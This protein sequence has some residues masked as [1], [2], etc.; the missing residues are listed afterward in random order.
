[1]KQTNSFLVT[2]PKPIVRISYPPSPRTFFRSGGYL[3]FPTLLQ[4]CTIVHKIPCLRHVIQTD[5]S[6]R[7]HIVTDSGYSSFSLYGCIFKI[8]LL[9]FSVSKHERVRLFTKSI[10]KIPIIIWTTNFYLLKE[11]IIKWVFRLCNKIYLAVAIKN[12]FTLL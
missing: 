11:F 6:E 7:E 10:L 9:L 5:K 8:F 12:F 2:V 1:M 4:L 3:L